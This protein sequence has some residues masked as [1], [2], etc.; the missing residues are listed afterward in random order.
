MP[1]PPLMSDGTIFR[2]TL[3]SPPDTV[4]LVH[5]LLSSVWE[6]APAIAMRDRFSFETALVELTSNVIKH[7]DKDT[8][9]TYT[10]TIHI[11]DDAVEAEVVD[12]GNHPHIE[13]DEYSMPDD[14]S[15]SGR[16]IPLIKTLVDHF[17]YDRNDGR[18]SW[19][20]SRTLQS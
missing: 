16:G 5:E 3:A 7:A 9:A 1:K 19:H 8:R 14:L 18:N 11:H 15:E 10:I 20:I 13:L 4:D 17:S 12:T 2:R 6:K